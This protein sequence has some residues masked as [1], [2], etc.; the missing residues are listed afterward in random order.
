MSWRRSTLP[1]PFDISRFN[2]QVLAGSKIH[3][4][5]GCRQ[6]SCSST[7]PQCVSSPATT[8]HNG[9]SKLSA[10]NQSERVKKCN[11]EQS[12]ENRRKRRT[13]EGGREGQGVYQ[14]QL[15]FHPNGDQG[16][17]SRKDGVRC[18]EPTAW[19]KEGDEEHGGTLHTNWRRSLGSNTQNGRKSKL[20]VSDRVSS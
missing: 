20:F 17:L 2:T 18:L 8:A 10:S 11:R 6:R 5:T 9:L 14:C 13:Q 1:I 16:C 4:T 12:R 3:S 7:V 15:D 19:P